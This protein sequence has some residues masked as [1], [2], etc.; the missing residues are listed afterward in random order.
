VTLKTLAIRAIAQFKRT[1]RRKTK[2]C[3]RLKLAF[4]VP[5]T[6]E[7]GKLAMLESQKRTAA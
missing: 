2:Q 5:G 3:G 1:N 6:P 4:N 7:A